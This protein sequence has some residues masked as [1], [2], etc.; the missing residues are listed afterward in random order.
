MK[1]QIFHR[2]SGREQDSSTIY[3]LYKKDKREMGQME[4]RPMTATGEVLGKLVGPNK[5]SLI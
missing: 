2:H 1:C 4:Q 5:K 3:K